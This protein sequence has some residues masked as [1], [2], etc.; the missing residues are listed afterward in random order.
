M[1]NFREA[2]SLNPQSLNAQLGLAEG[3]YAAGR[4]AV[5]A[6]EFERVL[7]LD[8]QNR[9]ALL[10]LAH[11]HSH[12]AGTWPRAV[13]DYR[14]YLK[15]NPGDAHATLGLARVLAWQRRAAEAAKLFERSDIAPL[16]TDADRRDYA[17]ALIKTGRGSQAESV[18]RKLLAKRHGDME[19]SLQLADIYAARKDWNAALPLYG[20]LLAKRPGDPSLNLSYGMGLL[21]TGRYHAALGPLEKARAAMPSNR[22]AGIAYARATKG[23]GNIKRAVKEYE[24]VLPQFDQDSSFLREYADVLLEKKDYKKSARSYGLAYSLGLRDDRLL[25]GYAGALMGAGKYKEAA[26]YLEE[27]YRRNPTPRTT[28]ELAKLMHRLGREERAKQL[29]SELETTSPQPA[30]SGAF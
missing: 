16:M 7:Q 24:R 4:E 1:V 18:L 30:K 2:L 15:Q 27:L 17:F 28:F 13:L 10:A 20:D 26:P 6:Q 14:T 3:E 25:A 8:N 22:Q 29:L 21:A 11:I 5:A 12:Q 23:T 19:S 9:S